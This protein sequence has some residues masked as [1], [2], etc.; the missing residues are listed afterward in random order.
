MIVTDGSNRWQ[1]QTDD[2]NRWQQM[3]PRTSWI[4]SQC[5]GSAPAPTPI[6][7][8]RAAIFDPSKVRKGLELVKLLISVRYMYWGD[9]LRRPNR[10]ECHSKRGGGTDWPSRYIIWRKDTASAAVFIC[11]CTSAYNRDV[12]AKL[13]NK[14]LA[15][16]PPSPYSSIPPP[17]L[18][19]STL[20]KM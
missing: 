17:S 8:M 7:I 3:M 19:P 13:C 1:Q 18:C 14:I 11:V 20:R 15:P 16:F 2:S 10:S 12:A 6:Y 9:N 5:W 4:C